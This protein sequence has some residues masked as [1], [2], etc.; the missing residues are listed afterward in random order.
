MLKLQ[1]TGNL[2]TDAEN[3]DLAGH[4][5]TCF[6][7]AENQVYKDRQTGEKK[8]KTTW[9]SCVKYGDNPGLLPFL[10]KGQRV[11]LEGEVYAKAYTDK[12]GQI[13]AGLNLRV[14][15]LELEGPA[16]SGSQQQ[17]PAQQYQQPQ[18]FQPQGY[19]PQQRQ[20]YAQ[21]APQPL[22]YPA[23]ELEPH[24]DDLPF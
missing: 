4:V 5:Y 3:R 13:T 10:K 9:I 20:Q 17:D 15:Y 21:P 11:Y 19:Q 2:G 14:T 16:P 1:V 6:K 22:N 8:T 23:S 7:I 24:D 18:S 12:N